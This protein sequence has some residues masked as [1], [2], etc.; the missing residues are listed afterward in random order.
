[1]AVFSRITLLAG[2]AARC[3]HAMNRRGLAMANPTATFKTTKGEFKVE[4]FQDQL[5]ITTSNFK[6]LATSGFYDGLTFHRVIPNFMCQF[7]CPN[8]ANPQSP[9]A[10]TGGP[11]G[12]TEFALPDGSK[13]KRDGGANIPDELVGELSNEVGTISMANTGAPN[14]GGSQ[15][16]LNTKH[17][18]FLDY[19]DNSTPSKHPVFGCC[20]RLISTRRVS[21]RSHAGKVVEGMD[22]V[23]A[24]E[25]VPTDGRDKPIDAVRVESITIEE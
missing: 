22:I 20:R 3:V 12:N 24:I 2:T 19:F 10:G 7:G 1:M 8:S 14:S 16:F 13:V 17:N 4:L 21:Y 6:D 11:P 15:F 23:T 25:G 5:P 9:I 18:A